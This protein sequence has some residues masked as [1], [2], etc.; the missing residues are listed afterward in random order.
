[1]IGEKK[2]KKGVRTEIEGDRGELSQADK[3]HQT[4]G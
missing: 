1:M 3:R 2:N 4:R